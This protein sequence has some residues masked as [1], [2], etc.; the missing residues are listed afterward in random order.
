MIARRALVLGGGATLLAGCTS[1]DALFGSLDLPA[2][3]VTRKALGQINDLRRSQ[4]LDP[5]RPDRAAERAALDAA[6]TMARRGRMEH[7]D[8]LTR[9][10]RNGV[11]GGAAENIARG[12]P[13]VETVM[14]VW[15]RS[16]GHRRNM[17]GD[18]SGLGVAVARNPD[19][20]NRPY[21]AMVLTT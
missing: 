11:D 9:V 6:R 5:V 20:D 19:T 2:D 3:V 7:G 15:I 18:F 16:S 12:Q 8:F 21:W 13:D 10:R 17:L 4:G 14:T 1:L